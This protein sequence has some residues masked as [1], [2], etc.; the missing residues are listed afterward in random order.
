MR[1]SRSIHAWPV[2]VA[3]ALAGIL[4]LA[5]A[6]ILSAA[7]ATATMTGAGSATVT[8]G[9]ST[10]VSITT[11]TATVEV[12]PNP[13]GPGISVGKTGSAPT[14]SFRFTASG[15]TPPGAYTYVFIDGDSQRSFTLTV[16]PAPVTTTTTTPPTATTLPPASSTT[17]TTAATTTTAAIDTTT[18]TEGIG[19]RIEIDAIA[20][21]TQYGADGIGH[22]TIVV[23]NTGSVTLTGIHVTDDL[24]LAI[25][26]N[27]DCA[28]SE[29]PDLGVGASYEYECAVANL[30]GESPFTNGATAIGF[31]PDGGRASNTDHTTVF[32]PVLATQVTQTT[33]TTTTVPE[34]TTTTT[35]L[36]SALAAG[37]GDNSGSGFSP[38]AAG[39]VVLIGLLGAA[40]V[41]LRSFRVP[42]RGAVSPSLASTRRQRAEQRTTEKRAAASKNATGIGEWWRGTAMVVGYREWRGRREAEKKLQRRIK[43]RRRIEER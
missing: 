10:V 17:S 18:T 30:D 26:P 7:P 4:V 25:D 31:G 2:A 13:G 41:A 29:L 40:A 23:T 22:F 6:L 32:P 8:Q 39:G 11:D 5:V 9:S 42:N 27:S 21:P 36:P 43:E 16:A 35:L 24:A 15:A 37:F 1:T 28:K 33:T 34:T 14:F 19:P 38:L 12:A 20:D 3:L